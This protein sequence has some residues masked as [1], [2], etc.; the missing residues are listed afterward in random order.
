M[1]VTKELLQEKLVITNLEAENANDAIEKLAKVLIENGCVKESYTKAVQDR[2]EAFPTGLPT[3]N[4]GVAIP[5]TEAM[6]VNTGAIALGILKNTVEFRMMGMPERT[7]DVKIIFM[8]AIEEPHGQIEMLQKIMKILQKDGLL[9][10]LQKC[11]R[12]RDVIDFFS[13]S[14]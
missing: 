13:E 11:T 10:E 8:M 12:P 4:I 14:I 5:H 9:E 3:E 6:H 1:T 7:V 2:E